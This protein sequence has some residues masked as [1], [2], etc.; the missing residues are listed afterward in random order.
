MAFMSVP[1]TASAWSTVRAEW[2]SPTPESQIGYQIRSASAG[3]SF[4]DRS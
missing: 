1:A 4:T 2:S 3:T